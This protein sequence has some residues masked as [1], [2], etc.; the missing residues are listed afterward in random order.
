VDQNAAWKAIFDHFVFGQ[1]DTGAHLSAEVRGL[2]GDIKPEQRNLIR[3]T[4]GRN[5]QD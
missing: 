4:I 1:T 2:L 5:L 3:R